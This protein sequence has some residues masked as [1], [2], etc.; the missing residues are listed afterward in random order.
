MAGNTQKATTVPRHQSVH[1]D[2]VPH[3]KIY[4]P[5]WGPGWNNSKK[6][7]KLIIM[8]YDLIW[9]GVPFGFLKVNVV[10]WTYNPVSNLLRICETCFPTSP[11]FHEVSLVCHRDHVTNCCTWD[12]PSISQLSWIQGMEIFPWKFPP[13]HQ[14]LMTL[15]G[16][17]KGQTKQL[18]YS[19]LYT[20]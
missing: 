2:H 3:P 14:L 15:L 1:E 13:E 7:S 11:K 6:K 19:I 4:L 9:G 17:W 10:L 18:I 16:E 12:T 8:W 5:W 20:P